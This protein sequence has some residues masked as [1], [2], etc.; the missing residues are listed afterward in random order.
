MKIG[1][2]YDSHRFTESRPLILGGVRISE[3]NGL[4]G[5]SDGDALSHAITD[6]ILGAAGSWD[7]GHYFPSSEPKWK[8]CDS[9]VLLKHAVKIVKTLGLEIGNIDATVVC[10][11]HRISPHRKAII[12]SLGGALEAEPGQIS[13][14]G[15]TNDKMGWIGSEVGLAV[16]VVTLLRPME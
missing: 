2:G 4:D 11:G 8:N 15:K 1:F 3:T 9:I 14:K 10:E 13:I 6:A 12:E 5:H 16:Y 7:I